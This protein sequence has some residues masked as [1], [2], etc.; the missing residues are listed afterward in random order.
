MPA[1]STTL[2]R[3]KRHSS[4]CGTGTEHRTAGIY[5]CGRTGQVGE[6]E[7]PHDASNR[8]L[9]LLLPGTREALANTSTKLD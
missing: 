3:A 8:D 9:V 7:T 4:D 5:L 2:P 1:N 6:D